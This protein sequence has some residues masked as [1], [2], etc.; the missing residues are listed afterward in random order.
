VELMADMAS[1]QEE[2]GP[3]HRDRYPVGPTAALRQQG[4]AG[5]RPHIIE[6]ESIFVNILF[7]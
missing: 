1:T 4:R 7:F 3:H 5:P 6:M 2:G